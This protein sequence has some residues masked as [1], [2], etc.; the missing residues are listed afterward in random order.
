VLDAFNIPY[1]N[2]GGGQ[3]VAVDIKQQEA[4]SAIK[5]SLL[6]EYAQTNIYKE[7][8][9][10][11]EGDVE[12]INIGG[13]SGNITDVY[14]TLQSTEYKNNITGAIVTGRKELPERRLKEQKD[15]L[16]GALRFDTTTMMTTCNMI[17]FTSHF[18][19]V[20][21]DP[22]LSSAANYEDGI[23]TIY[24]N[25]RLQPYERVV[26]W[27]YDI[28]TT[29]DGQELPP[30][31]TVN[32]QNTAS[33][34][35]KISGA[36]YV[37][38]DDILDPPWNADLGTLINRE[39]AESMEAG[40]CSPDM[41]YAGDDYGDVDC[42][43]TKPLKVELDPALRY[44]N[45]RGCAKDKFLQVSKIWFIA[46]EC[47]IVRAMPKNVDSALATNTPTSAEADI[48]V[49]LQ[50]MAP[51]IIGLD[52]GGDY[53]IG[54]DAEKGT[55]CVQFVANPRQNEHKI[56]Y[57]TGTSFYLDPNCKYAT[58]A[59]LT[60]AALELNGTLFPAAGGKGYLV[61]QVWAQID[62]A[63]PSIVINSPAGNAAT[64]NDYI[65][66]GLQAIVVEDQ[67]PHVAINGE[68]VDQTLNYQDQ[69]PTTTQD[70]EDTDYE[71]KLKAIDYGEGVTITLSSLGESSTENL[72]RRLHNLM[73]ADTGIETVYTCGP[74]CQPQLGGIGNSGGII[75]NITYSYSDRGSY[76]ISVN[77]GPM[78]I[79]GLSGITTGPH[80]KKA[81]TVS[82]QGTVVGAYGDGT[83]FKVLVDGIGV[84]EAIN[85]CP[86][87]IRVGDK[88]SVT[89]HNN[90]VEA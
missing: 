58:D 71:R 53:G 32:F 30:W 65:S 52:R 86:D 5:A 6:E 43:G 37:T 39:P 9:V 13:V 44:D 89:I 46:A 11:E 7:I 88:V 74:T 51:K 18:T 1:T 62:L 59:G 67:P 2:T 57:G 64:Y 22:H 79:G 28:D 40:A 25:D 82:E 78:F 70:L 33:V 23:E 48:F 55:I 90:P 35:L 17:N 34:P 54:Y 83:N 26:G 50:T 87:V 66:V 19:I 77:E 63:S 36:D 21:D 47:D 10:N 56:Q 60:G 68:L 81:D 85:C 42:A 75:N 80:V 45:I 12:F 69:D 20:Y 76:T 72:S 41:G 16:E 14:Y 31:V 3:L 38:K 73:E 8:I 15:L 84:R 29:K 4:S 24:Q 27:V 49:S 61:Y